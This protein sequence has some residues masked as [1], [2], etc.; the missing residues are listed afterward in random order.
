MNQYW[1]HDADPTAQGDFLAQV[2]I[3]LKEGAFRRQ[4]GVNNKGMFVLSEVLG[5]E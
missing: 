1:G 3:F 4:A 5:L 2:E